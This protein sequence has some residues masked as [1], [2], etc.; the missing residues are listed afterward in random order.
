MPLRI[1]IDGRHI[2]DFGIGTYIRNAVRA[3]ARIDREDDFFVVVGPSDMGELA[4]LPANF[5]VVPYSTPNNSL[6]RFLGV[7]GFLRRFR[8]DVYHIPLNAV[9]FGMPRPYVVTVHDMSSLL[10]QRRGDLRQSLRLRQYRRGLVGAEQ[11]IAVSEATRRDLQ[12]TLGIRPDRI[13]MIYNAPDPIFTAPVRRMELDERS[14]IMERYQINYPYLLYAGNIRPQKNVPRVI[15]AFAVLKGELGSHPVY[16]D[17]R[18]IIIGD[19]I[20]K[21]PAVRH[22]VIQSRVE[23][24]VRFLGFVPIHTLRIFYKSAAVFVFPSLYEGFGLPPLEAMASGIPVVTSNVS[25]LP[26]VVGD[27]AIMVD[28]ESVFEIARG[29]REALL[30]ESVRFRCVERGYAQVQRFSWDRNAGQLLETYRAVASAG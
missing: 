13:R 26:E 25:S 4:K 1:V 15:E 29:M 20:S 21:Y 7:P 30:D 27:A 10:F 16:S 6:M 8:A 9:P 17:L 22:A 3:L 11:I 5:R 12:N 24:C 18:L 19:E 2:R 23:Q 14:R 28:P